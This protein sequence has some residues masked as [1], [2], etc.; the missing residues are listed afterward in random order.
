MVVHTYNPSTL[1]AE[2]CKFKGSLVYISNSRTIMMTKRD[3]DQGEYEYVSYGM[4]ECM[5]GGACIPSIS[6]WDTHP[7]RAYVLF[8]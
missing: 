3:A 2:L 4:S 6:H 5:D 8:P 1:K 7:S